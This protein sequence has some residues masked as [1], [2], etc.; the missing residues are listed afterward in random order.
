MFF[1]WKQ[2][3]VASALTASVLQIKREEHKEND[4]TPAFLLACHV[5]ARRNITIVKNWDAS[6]G[7]LV[8]LFLFSMLIINLWSQVQMSG[9]YLRLIF[10]L[11]FSPAWFC[12]LMKVPQN[13]ICVQ[14][15][16]PTLE[17]VLLNK[18]QNHIFC[19]FCYLLVQLPSIRLWAWLFICNTI[20]ERNFTV[21]LRNIS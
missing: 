10:L 4:Y 11:V 6:D 2:S 12:T 16:V 17:F 18:G 7:N 1:C 15:N 3:G 19:T 21:S 13:A 20:L 8:S 5:I 9:K 14:L